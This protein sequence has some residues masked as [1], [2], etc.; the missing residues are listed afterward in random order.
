[1][2]FNDEEKRNKE[3]LQ[4]VVLLSTEMDA[5]RNTNQ[6]LEVTLEEERKQRIMT[7]KHSGHSSENDTVVNYNLIRELEEAHR[8]CH[9][10]IKIIERTAYQDQYSD[11]S[12]SLDVSSSGNY[13][14]GLSPTKL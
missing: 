4:T 6:T 12:I 7:L 5:L 14:S 2:K 1:M 3:L 13:P 8:R 9:E 10:D 11:G